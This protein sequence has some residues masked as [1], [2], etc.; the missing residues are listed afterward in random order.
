MRDAER[1]TGDDLAVVDAAREDLG[2]AVK[3]PSP[4]RWTADEKARIVRESFRSGKEV[5]EVAQHYGVPRKRLSEWRSLARQ[6]K[7]DVASSLASGSGPVSAAPETGPAFAAVEVEDAPGSAGSVA[8]EAGG[9][10]VRIGGDSSVAR[11][12]EIAAALRR[13]R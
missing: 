10:T 9:V 2:A 13:L 7:L 6:G 3:R 11:I 1:S 12:A 5:G 8:I 4:R